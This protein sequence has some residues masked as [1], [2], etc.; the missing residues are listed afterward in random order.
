MNIELHPLLAQGTGAAAP[1]AV[2]FVPKPSTASAMANRR[3][4]A[5]AAPKSARKGAKDPVAEFLA[6]KPAETATRANPYYDP[7]LAAAPANS[8]VKRAL[9]FNPKGK[10]VAMAKTAR[11]EAQMAMLKR[12]IAETT[13]ESG[14]DLDIVADLLNMSVDFLP[15][16]DWWDLPFLPGGQF[17]DAAQQAAS[18]ALVNHLVQRP[19]L[20]QPPADPNV[21]VAPKPL[22]LT[23]EE[24]KKIRRQRRLQE[25][26]DKQEK[27]RLGLLPPDAPKVRVANIASILAAESAQE[28]SRIETE[29]RQQAASRHEAHLKANEDRRLQAKASSAA[30][31]EELNGVV[32]VAVFAVD[33]IDRNQ[34]KYKIKVNAQQNGLTG[35]CISSPKTN[36]VVA[37]GG[38]KGIKHYKA[39]LLRR[40]NWNEIDPAAD[41]T[42]MEAD[43]PPNSCRLLWEG[44]VASQTWRRFEM[45]S[46]PGEIDVKDYFVKL[47]L[48]NYW[49][50]AK[51]Q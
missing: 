43:R 22:A 24:Q 31:V 27:I 3:A 23:K 40:I 12:D 34:W 39:L 49:N 4:A 45:H 36:L 1:S 29:I 48:E 6:L 38:P 10:F 13:L 20:L 18:Y 11:K 33:R 46:F 16:V 21:L 41:S 15:K 30:K 26:K 51:K 7:R 32:Q 35:C 14:M 28:P 2:P 9:V 17:A 47:S 42:Q 8:H 44:V 5:A 25:Q 19:A 37:E 50:L